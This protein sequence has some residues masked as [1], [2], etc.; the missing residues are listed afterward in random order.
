VCTPGEHRLR[1][2]GAD[3]PGILQ[4]VITVDTPASNDPIVSARRLVQELRGDYL[5]MVFYLGDEHDILH[6]FRV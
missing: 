4:P 5:G 6:T 1:E 3:V 2:P